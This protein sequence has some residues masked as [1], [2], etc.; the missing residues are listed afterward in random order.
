M[1]NAA[2]WTRVPRSLPTIAVAYEFATEPK[3]SVGNRFDPYSERR[4]S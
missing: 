3:D 4:P 2:C 1:I